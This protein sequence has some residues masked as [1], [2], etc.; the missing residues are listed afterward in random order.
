MMKRNY[1]RIL[2]F[3]L[4]S[5][6]IFYG[7]GQQYKVG[8]GNLTY[9]TPNGGLAKQIKGEDYVVASEYGRIATF[10]AGTGNDDAI[11]YVGEGDRDLT[12][13][14]Y[15]LYVEDGLMSESLKIDNPQ[16]WADF[17]FEESYELHALDVV[18]AYIEEHRHLPDIPSEQ[19][20]KDQGYYD[21]HE[22]NKLMLQ[23]IE[24]LTLYVIEQQKEIRD[25]KDR[26]SR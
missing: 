10:E 21:Q 13:A 6:V 22:M 12:G 20:L 2:V 18:E 5:S 7:Y 3:S 4:C 8:P 15:N 23:K 26:L 1:I 19:E 17:V 25:L 9:T 24:E 16:D 14:D 11:L